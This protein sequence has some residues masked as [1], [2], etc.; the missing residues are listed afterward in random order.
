MSNPTT[1]TDLLKT[2][3][4][5]RDALETQIQA[6]TNEDIREGMNISIDMLSGALIDAG[7]E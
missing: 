2:I 3:K 6:E 7:W 4:Q 5:V 1:T